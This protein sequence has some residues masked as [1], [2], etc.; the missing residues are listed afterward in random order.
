[1][2]VLLVQVGVLQDTLKE[3]SDF[4]AEDFA[5]ANFTDHCWYDEEHLAVTT[6]RG[7]LLVSPVLSYAA[8]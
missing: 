2:A 7:D 5:S 1:M 8:L 6:E 4:A 3:L